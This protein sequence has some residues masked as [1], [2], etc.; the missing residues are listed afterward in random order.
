[1][2][3]LE[4]IESEE[5]EKLPGGIFTVSYLKQYALAIGLPE[6]EILEHYRRTLDPPPTTGKPETP[7]ERNRALR[8][9]AN[10]QLF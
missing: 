7:P 10:F 5:F 1:M 6:E 9:L 3:F 8:V 4:A 2:R